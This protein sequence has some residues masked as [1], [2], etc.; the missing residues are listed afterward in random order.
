MSVESI[1]ALA[2]A[3]A[4][5]IRQFPLQLAAVSQLIAC[6]GLWTQIA[7]KWSKFTLHRKPMML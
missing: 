1:A 2:A 6:F 3:A 4:A 7:H 5:V